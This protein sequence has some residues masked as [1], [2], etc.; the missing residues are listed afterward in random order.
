MTAKTTHTT[1]RQISVGEGTTP[2]RKIP[3]PDTNTTSEVSMIVTTPSPATNFPRITSSRWIGWA[4]RRGSVPCDRSPFTASKPN[5]I[6]RSGA[7]NP[8]KT[9]RGKGTGPSSP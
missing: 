5:M 6:P 3:I 4:R 8:T 7:R 2:R 1:R 9:M